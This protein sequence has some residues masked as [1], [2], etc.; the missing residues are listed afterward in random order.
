M[1]STQMSIDRRVDYE[2]RIHAQNA[3]LFSLKKDEINSQ[4]NG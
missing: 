2:N 4:K 3:M 1:E